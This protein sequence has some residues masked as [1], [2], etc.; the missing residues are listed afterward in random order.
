MFPCFDHRAAA[1]AQATILSRPTYACVVFCRR[2]TRWH[3]FASLSGAAR[4][5]RSSHNLRSWVVWVPA[6]TNRS[7]LM[8]RMTP[9]PPE[10]PNVGCNLHGAS[11]HPR[12]TLE[13]GQM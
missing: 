7:Y 5:I 10:S 12:T 1:A 9:V 2:V 3:S 6:Q 13:P 11:K 4:S 8:P